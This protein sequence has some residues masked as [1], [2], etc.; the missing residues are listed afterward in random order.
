LQERFPN[1][2]SAVGEERYI[3]VDVAQTLASFLEDARSREG[4]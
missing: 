2:L 3:S 1:I 4:Y